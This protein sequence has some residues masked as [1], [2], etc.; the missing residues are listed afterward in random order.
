MKYSIPKFHGV[1]N[2]TQSEENAL[3]FLVKK[4]VIKRE[5]ICCKYQSPERLS[6]TT[7]THRSVD[8]RCHAEKSYLVGIFFAGH[9]LLVKEII[10]IGYF[11]LA[12][13]SN[14]QIETYAGVTNKTVTAFVNYFQQLIEDSL[15]EIDFTVGGPG[16]IAEIDETK[17]G[18]RKY[19]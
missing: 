6:L 15:Y 4:E 13:A 10:R 18:K 7:K 9:K 1:I 5:T 14:M 19:N 3:N 12:K 11:W 16:I 17:L 2:I 8:Y